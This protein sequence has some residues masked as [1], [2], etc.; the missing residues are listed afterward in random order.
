MSDK[1][2]F[3]I[4]W[5]CFWALAQLMAGFVLVFPWFLVPFSLLAI[6]LPVGSQR[7]P[8]LPPPGYPVGRNP[9]VLRP[10]RCVN[11]GTPFEAHWQ[12]RCPYPVRPR[13]LSR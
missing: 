6:L 13:E 12:G 7:P 8:Q 2:I 5:C 10:G 11:C 9:A 3:W 1:R 4:A